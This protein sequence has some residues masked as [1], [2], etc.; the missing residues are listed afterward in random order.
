LTDHMAEAL[1][2]REVEI[3]VAIEKGKDGFG[4][5]NKIKSYTK[6]APVEKKPSAKPAW[7]AKGN[8]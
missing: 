6:S 4:D 8:R 2:N 7:A 3:N 1:Y 5:K